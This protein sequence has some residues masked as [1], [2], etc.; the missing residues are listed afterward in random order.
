MM[1][2]RT[3]IVTCKSVSMDMYVHYDF[4][5]DRTVRS[6][7]L[8]HRGL[9]GANKFE[10]VGT[11]IIFKSF[12][13]LISDIWALVKYSN[14]M[15]YCSLCDLELGE[16]SALG[17]E[18]G[19][20]T[21]PFCHGVV[22]EEGTILVDLIEMESSLD[23]NDVRGM[24]LEKTSELTINRVFEIIAKSLDDSPYKEYREDIVNL[25]KIS[26]EPRA[27]NAYAEI[28]RLIYENLIGSTAKIDPTVTRA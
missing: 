8:C 13:M 22:E 3:N 23:R 10:V 4:L 11:E 2:L 26:F 7:S 16:I 28:A 19:H 9:A 20:P 27:K 1:M 24:N 25:I 5:R 6:P 21:C 18:N 14:H 12:S 15:W 17:K